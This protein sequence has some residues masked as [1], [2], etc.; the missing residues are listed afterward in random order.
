M[1]RGENEYP[2]VLVIHS[3]IIVLPGV[4]PRAGT[5]RWMQAGGV[6]SGE[7]FLA[8]SKTPQRVK[9]YICTLQLR[10]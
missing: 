1:M 8:R 9:Y 4:V 6:D 2:S 10:R 5:S 7:G 3:P